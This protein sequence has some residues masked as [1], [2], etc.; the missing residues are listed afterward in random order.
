MDRRAFL[1]LTRKTDV[2]ELHLAEGVRG[3]LSGLTPYSGPWTNAE[4]AH[5]LKRTMFGAAKADIDYFRSMSTSQ[6]VDALLNI[7]A[8]AQPLPLKDYDNDDIPADDGDFPVPMWST[9]I[10]T[11]SKDG[12]AN[13]KRM[14]SLKSWWIGQMVNQDRTITEKLILFWHNHF[15]TESNEYNR[16]RFGYT[17]YLLLRQFALGN[18]KQFTRAI[19]LDK[20]MLR[21]LNGYLNSA[22]A[23]DENYARELQELFTLGKENNPNYTEPDVFSAARVLT[24]WQINF[25]TEVVTFNINRHDKNNKVFSSFFGG[26]TIAGRADASAGDTE[27]DDLLNMIFAKNIEVS[28]FIVRKIYRWFCY[29]TIDTDTE[30]NVIKP[31]A[32][33]FRDGNWEIKPVLSALFKS[34]HFFDVLNYGALIKSP[35]DSVVGM[36]REF[37]VQFPL[38]SNNEQS[39][40]CWSM[41]RNFAYVMQQNLFDPPGVSGWPAYYQAPQF[42]EM[43]IN[44]DTLPKR[45]GFFDFLTYNGFTAGGFTM[46]L[47]PVAFAKSLPS[48]GDPNALINDSLTMMYRV[49]ISDQSKQTIKKQILLTNQDQDYYWTNAWNSYVGNPA[50]TT[51]YETVYNRLRSLYRYLMNLAE[52]QLV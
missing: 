39:Y 22:G 15:A 32:Q 21:Y 30:T 26:T 16:G 5:L 17:H 24:G 27:L 28:E 51:A 18:F 6:A 35:I 40:L 36:C 19:T 43:W 34:E 9:W 47:D 29:Y 1:S 31:L 11:V 44:S 52:Y 12:N 25:D 41:M 37:N 33:L 7:S 4:V 8:A 50:D 45:T 48:P 3:I 10:N 13:A 14:Q 38:A 20:A 2:P 42:H 46:I 49:P 23:P